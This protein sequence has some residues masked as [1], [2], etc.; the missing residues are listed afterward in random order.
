MF[1]LAGRVKCKLRARALAVGVGLCLFL[2]TQSIVAATMSAHLDRDSVGVGESVTLTLTFEG[3]SPN[4]PPNL[5]ALP[6]VQTTFAGQSSA[7]N[8]VNGVSTTSITFS[9]T[10]VPTQPGEVTIPAM[11]AQVGAQVMTSQ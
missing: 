7:F 3:V 2:A 8:F 10:L 6:N 1:N 11:Q 4:T 9:Y 5:P